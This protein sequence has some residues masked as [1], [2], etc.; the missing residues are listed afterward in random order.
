MKKYFAFLVVL[1]VFAAR[2]SAERVMVINDA[3]SSPITGASVFSAT[4]LILGMTDADGITP[5]LSDS[6]FPLSVRSIAFKEGIIDKGVD[7]LRMKVDTYD[8]PG[9]TVKPGE[10]PIIHIITYVR[11]FC[12][13]ATSCDTAMA[14][15]EYMLESFHVED[16]VKGFRRYDSLPKV[17]ADLHYVRCTGGSWGDSVAL[18]DKG[19]DVANE[20][21]FVPDMVNL[22]IEETHDETDA[23]KNGA[24]NDTV[25]GEYGPAMVIRK[26]ETAYIVTGDLLSSKKNHKYSPNILKLLGMT[27]EF[28]EIIASFAYLPNDKGKYDINDF[29]YGTTS[30]KALGKGKWIKKFLNVKESVDMSSFIEVY[31]VEITYLTLDEYKEMRDNRE[32]IEFRRPGYMLPLLPAV[33][34]LTESVAGFSKQKSIGS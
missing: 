19:I 1:S 2:L 13:G 14:F 31:P 24:L 25:Q 20:L 23:I 30:I 34:K 12:N 7:T 32:T 33:K 27:T 11:E 18:A 6:D 28:Y 21:S 15:S 9:V 26:G 17:K 16:K 3:D 8:L 29:I 10:R 22:P 4:G 5:E